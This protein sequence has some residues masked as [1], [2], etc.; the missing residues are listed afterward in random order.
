[1]LSRI[2]NSLFWMGRYLERIEHMARFAKVQYFSSLDAPTSLNKKRV[3]ESMLEMNGLSKNFCKI[4]DEEVLFHISIARTNSYSMLSC[5]NSARENARGA[6]DTISSELWETINTYFNK[7][8]EFNKKPFDTDEFIGIVEIILANSAIIKGLIDNT[9]FHRDE[10]ALICEGIHLERAIQV[11]RILVSKLDEIAHIEK[12]N[13]ENAVE[14]FQ[15]GTLLKSAESFDM[16]HR[17]YRKV[18]NKANTLEFLLFNFEFPK[19]L[20]FNLAQAER[21][22]VTIAKT[23]HDINSSPLYLLGKL[24]AKIR[25]TKLEEVSDDITTFANDNLSEIYRIAAAIENKYLSY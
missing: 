23:N 13:V 25:Y 4:T 20:A 2:A 19:S 16:C 14:T 5:L 22:L 10:R 7:L 8:N 9:L 6:R 24:T 1:M 3:L 15:W 11:S 18:P 17:F 12:S 21:H